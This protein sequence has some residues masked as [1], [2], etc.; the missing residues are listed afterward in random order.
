MFAG[1]R[2]QGGGRGQGQDNG[3]PQDQATRDAEREAMR[4]TMRENSAALQQ[5]TDLELK[6]I[7]NKTLPPTKL[8]QF[9]RLR[10]IELQK[11]GPLVVSR[12]DVSHELNLSSS[13]IDQIQSVMAQ[14]NEGQN[15]VSS[16]RRTLFGQRRPDN[17]SDADRDARRTKEAQERTKLENQGKSLMDQAIAAVSKVLS[18]DQ[19]KTF[20]DKLQG[21]PFDLTKLNDGRGVESSFAGNNF[22]R[23]GPPN[24]PPPPTTT[25]ANTTTPAKGATPPTKGAT[26]PTKG[27][28]T[29]STATAPGAATKTQGTMGRPATNR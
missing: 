11:E 25:A 26:P 27:T 18:K 20:N 22:G 16:S 6:K 4:S 17:E 12:A 10:Q 19:K 24:N 5:Q 7:L 14:F 9:A 29:S 23:G 15:Q 13:Q 1:M 21:K 3:Q 28:T 8:D 2:N